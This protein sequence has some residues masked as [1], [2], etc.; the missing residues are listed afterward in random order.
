MEDLKRIKFD[1][2]LPENKLQQMCMERLFGIAFLSLNY[3]INSSI[4]GNHF[5]SELD[6]NVIEKYILARK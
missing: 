6:S 1:S 2:I 5:L 4:Q 3:D